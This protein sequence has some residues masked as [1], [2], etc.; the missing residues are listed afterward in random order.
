MLTLRDQIVH[1]LCASISSSS[2]TFN[3]IFRILDSLCCRQWLCGKMFKWELPF[4]C[5]NWILPMFI[6]VQLIMVLQVYFL[7]SRLRNVTWLIWYCSCSVA[8]E[9]NSP[10]LLTVLETGTYPTQQQN[11]TSLDVHQHQCEDLTK[12]ATESMAAS[13]F[14]GLHKA[15]LTQTSFPYNQGILV[16]T[17]HLCMK[18][19]F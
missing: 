19:L 6:L 4:T 13:L 9:L 16:N 15:F 5:L 1:F 12:F 10:P 7:K 8:I 18:E 17:Y 14:S 11:G 3:L 2:R